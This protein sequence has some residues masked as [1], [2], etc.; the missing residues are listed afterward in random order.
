MEGNVFNRMLK[1]ILKGV[2]VVSPLIII[3]FVISLLFNLITEV[4]DPISFIISGERNPAFVL[5]FI[6]LIIMLILL[7]LVGVFIN[8]RTG[9]YYWHQFENKYLSIIP[10]YNPVK[11]TIQQFTGQKDMPFKH[12]VLV[13]IFGSGTRMTGFV[14]QVTKN[15]YYT[16]FVPTA[17]NPMNGNIYHVP[18]ELVQFV[19]VS[20]ER[21]MRSII[22]LGAGSDRVMAEMKENPFPPT[23]TPKLFEEE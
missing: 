5:R 3:V 15:Q 21:A 22:S 18:R 6:S 23:D 12:V 19:D 16:V 20:P 4:L 17:P 14:T 13:D 10:L 8:T 9:K 2:L 7:Y 11:E 1:T